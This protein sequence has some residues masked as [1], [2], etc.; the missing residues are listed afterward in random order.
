MFGMM[1]PPGCGIRV[2]ASSPAELFLVKQGKCWKPRVTTVHLVVRL[3]KGVHQVLRGA[4]RPDA[5]RSL[6]SAIA[7]LLLLEGQLFGSFR[8]LARGRGTCEL[9]RMLRWRLRQVHC[10][11]SRWRGHVSVS[12]MR[13]RRSSPAGSGRMLGRPPP[14]M[15]TLLATPCGL[16][17]RLPTASPNP[18]RWSHWLWRL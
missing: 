4:P 5:L 8:S 18:C 14:D 16:V 11:R 7:G 17:R 15:M 1:A 6:A 3:V 9:W 2:R 12:L 13:W 10:W